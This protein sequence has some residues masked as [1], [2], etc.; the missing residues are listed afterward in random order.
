GSQG[1]FGQVRELGV[2][3]VHF[4]KPAILISLL[5]LASTTFSSICAA[6]QGRNTASFPSISSLRPPAE[7]SEIEALAR[8]SQLEVSMNETRTKGFAS[9]CRAAADLELQATGYGSACE[10]VSPLQSCPELLKYP[11]AV[12]EL[13][14]LRRRASYRKSAKIKKRSRAAPG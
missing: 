2:S 9:S 3:K 12:D 1:G 7:P 6:R 8:N 14:Q 11:D 13:C 10:D 4:P 5:A